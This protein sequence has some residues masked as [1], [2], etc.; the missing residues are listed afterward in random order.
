MS[1]SEEDILKPAPLFFILSLQSSLFFYTIKLTA[2]DS[3]FFLFVFWLFNSTPITE[4]VLRYRVKHLWLYSSPEVICLADS[5]AVED[6]WE[7]LHLKSEAIRAYF[8][9]Q[10][11]QSGRGELLL[12]R[13]FP[14]H[15]CRRLSCHRSACTQEVSLG[16]LCNQLF[17]SSIKLR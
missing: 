7:I 17:L 1:I 2:I 3:H 4:W 15:I 14:L 10:K 6:G 11:S 12:L 8:K 13:I 16:F 9:Y 5:R